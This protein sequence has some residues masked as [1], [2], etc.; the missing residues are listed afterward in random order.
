LPYD[1]DTNDKLSLAASDEIGGSQQQL[2]RPMVGPISLILFLVCPDTLRFE[3][4]QLE[5]ETPQYMIVANVLDQL[6]NPRAFLSDFHCLC[7]LLFAH[8]FVFN[9]LK[10]PDS[11]LGNSC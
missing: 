2:V 8:H 10:N 9:C 1:R 5:F 3:F 4:L 11:I 7:F 6:E